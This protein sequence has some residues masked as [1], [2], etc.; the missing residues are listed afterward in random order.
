MY[1]HKLFS[2][3][4]GGKRSPLECEEINKALA[5]VKVEDLPSEQYENTK[6]YILQALNY[7]SVDTSL[8]Q[9]LRA[10]LVMWK[11]CITIKG[12]EHRTRRSFSSYERPSLTQK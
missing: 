6:S 11:N 1:L 12:G 5:L 2:I 3:K 8:V 9:A 4:Y 7:N 10:C